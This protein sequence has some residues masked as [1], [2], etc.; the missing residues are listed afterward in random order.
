[1][2]ARMPDDPQIPTTTNGAE[3][4]HRHFKNC[5]KT[6][7]PNIYSLSKE[8]LGLQEET[9]VKLRSGNRE[10]SNRLETVERKKRIA[11]P[12]FIN[13]NLAVSFKVV[14]ERILNFDKID[15][16]KSIHKSKLTKV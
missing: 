7:H 11:V 5:F 14:L 10:N 1:M 3:A 6:P 13:E 4:F 12:E 9:Y 15:L 2:W 8:L 16:R